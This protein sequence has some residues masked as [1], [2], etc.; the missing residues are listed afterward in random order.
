MHFPFSHNFLKGKGSIKKNK[1]NYF[2]Q[3]PYPTPQRSRLGSATVRRAA[4]RQERSK[5]RYVAW[6]IY[7]YS[8]ARSIVQ[9]SESSMM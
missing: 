8:L 4:G 2:R 1:C 5:S 3:V 7:Q 6:T 9:W